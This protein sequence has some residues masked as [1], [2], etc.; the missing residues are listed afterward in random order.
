[1]HSGGE[2]GTLLHL[3]RMK[4]EPGGEFRTA[5]HFLSA[6]ASE[7]RVSKDYLLGDGDGDGDGD[8]LAMAMAR[9]LR[10]LFEMM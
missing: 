8:G 7:L 9:C 2:L 1:M 10:Y 5:H 6:I 4:F 3:S